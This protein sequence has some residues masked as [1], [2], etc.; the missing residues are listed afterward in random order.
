MVQSKL[1]LV[2]LRENS[3]DVQVSVGL[4]LWSLQTRFDCQ[5]SLKEV[6]SDFHLVYPTVVACHVVVGHGLAKFIILTQ[7]F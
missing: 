5:S 4:N 6:K 2:Q 3:T 7:V 1:M